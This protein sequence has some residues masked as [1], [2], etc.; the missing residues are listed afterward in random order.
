MD[1]NLSDSQD[2]LSAAVAV[3]VMFTENDAPL[4]IAAIFTKKERSK[5]ERGIVNKQWLVVPQVIQCKSA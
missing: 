2:L 3:E 5:Q 4:P 1:V